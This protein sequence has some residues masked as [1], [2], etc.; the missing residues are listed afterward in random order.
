MIRSKAPRSTT[1]SLITGNG[2][3]SPRL[4]IDHVAVVEGAHVE[5]AGR[6]LLRAVRDAVD[7]QPAHAADALAAVAVE[8]DRILAL[9]ESVAR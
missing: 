2:V 4:D 7:H 5:L 9:G 3:G 1:R 8:G 6:G